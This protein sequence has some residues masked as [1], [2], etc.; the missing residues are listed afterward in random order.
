MAGLEGGD[1]K[2]PAADIVGELDPAVNTH[3][4]VDPISS[5]LAASKEMKVSSLTFVIDFPC[6]C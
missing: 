3:V 6:Q 2:F 5:D 1:R 4:Q